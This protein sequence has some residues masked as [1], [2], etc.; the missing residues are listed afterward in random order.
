MTLDNKKLSSIKAR[1]KKSNAGLSVMGAMGLIMEFQGMTHEQR[2]Q[3][4][5]YMLKG[6]VPVRFERLDEM[7]EKAV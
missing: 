6:K 7:I 1:V 2:V 4:Q 3:V 5:Q